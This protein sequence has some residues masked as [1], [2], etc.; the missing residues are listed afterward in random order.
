MDFNLSEMQRMLLDS[1]QRYIGDHYSLEHRRSLRATPDGLDR[2]AGGTFAELGWLAILLPE[3]LGGIGGTMED[4]AVLSNA[5][6]KRCVTE[7]FTSNAIL[8]A[9]VLAGSVGE[10]SALCGDLV[11][12]QAR[13]ALADTEQG[14]RYSHAGCRGVK[15]QER[16]GRLFMSGQKVMVMDAP[17]ATHFL[18]T[19][20]R[21]QSFVLVLVEATAPGV[22]R[23][24]YALYDGSRASDLTF[25]TE[26]EAEQI[27]A[28]KEVAEDLLALALD[29]SR[30]ALAAQSVGSM[31]A[32]LEICSAYLKERQQFG[33]PI[34]KFQALQHIMADMFVAT[35]QARSMLYFALSQLDAAQKQ[36]EQAVALARAHISEAAQLVS[37]QAIQLHGGYGVTDEYEV[38]HHYRRQLILE[39]TYGDVT[40]CLAR[41]VG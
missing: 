15:L 22:T 17:S 18:V 5:L 28:V 30:V 2:D 27:L 25:D 8:A 19:A 4:A 37:R 31:E 39:K 21:D 12:G 14:E 34:G 13:F 7:P 26:L 24:D 6:G 32:E 23:A 40:W 11:S 10:P 38:S 1:A 35:H 33:Q 3:H 16:D 29:R 41:A 9:T 20:E 36:R